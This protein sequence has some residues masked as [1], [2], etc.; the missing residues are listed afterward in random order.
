MT[1]FDKLKQMNP[2]EFARFIMD[3]TEHNDFFIFNGDG[4]DGEWYEHHDFL[5]WLNSEIE[6]SPRMVKQ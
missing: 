4:I 1:N 6:E 5:K 3:G 2:A